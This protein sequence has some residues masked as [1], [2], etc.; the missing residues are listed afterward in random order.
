MIFWLIIDFFLV[1]LLISFVIPVPVTDK[2]AVRYRSVPWMTVAL[3]ATNSIVYLFWQKP[4]EAGGDE[5]GFINHTMSYASQ[6]D[7]VAYKYGIGGFSTFTGMFMHGDSSHLLGNMVYLWAF[8][9][10]VED[11]CGPWRFLLFYMIA[12]TVATMGYYFIV[13]DSIGGIGASGA[14]SG[15]MGAYMVL[16]PGARVGCLWMGFA[17]LR[18]VLIGLARVIGLQFTFRWL[19]YIPAFIVLIFY[20]GWDVVS[21]LETAETGEMPGG[22]NYVA[23]TAGFLSAVTV[24]LFVRKD[25]FVRYF[26]GRRI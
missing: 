9:R 13:N 7:M 24:L 18:G 17:I 23:H 25:L 16:F 14:I 11:A 26:S 22:V 15:V 4:P 2:G 8:G 12:G 21:T 10:R 3:I 6:Y 1:L 5:Y 20:V 19:V